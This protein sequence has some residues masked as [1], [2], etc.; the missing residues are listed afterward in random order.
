MSEFDPTVVEGPLFN[1][2]LDHRPRTHRRRENPETSNEAAIAA[3]ADASENCRKI[4]A[5]L[6]RVETATD[7]EGRADTGIYSY[8][9]RRADL[10]NAGLVE[11]SGERRPSARGRRMVAW[12]IT[13]KRC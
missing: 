9:R 11:D 12:K 4:L 3:I 10:L 6:S 1:R 5:Y 2:G 8:R 7:E 13:R